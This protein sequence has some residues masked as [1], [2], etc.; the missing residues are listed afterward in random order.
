MQQERSTEIQQLTLEDGRVETTKNKTKGQKG[1]MVMPLP[2][3]KT[4]KS[5]EEYRGETSQ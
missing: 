5:E 2:L 1:W 4:Q 3:T